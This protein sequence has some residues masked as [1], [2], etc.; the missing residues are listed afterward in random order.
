MKHSEQLAQIADI[1]DDLFSDCRDYVH[2]DF[3]LSS[4]GTGVRYNIYTP[5]INHNNFDNFKQFKEFLLSLKANGDRNVRKK[6]LHRNLEDELKSKK[7]AEDRIRE[8]HSELQE[9]TK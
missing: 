7:D 5:I 9:Y 3:V 4:N 1:M 8:I 2:F 6:I